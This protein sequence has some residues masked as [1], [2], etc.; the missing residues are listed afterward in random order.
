MANDAALDHKM[1]EVKHSGSHNR[2][3]HRDRQSKR[4][5]GPAYTAPDRLQSNIL[6]Y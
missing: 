2:E 4:G 1:I 6:N 5:D 3:E